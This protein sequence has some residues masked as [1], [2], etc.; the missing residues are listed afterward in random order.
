M[1]TDME[2]LFVGL[3]SISYTILELGKI[4][5]DSSVYRTHIAHRVVLLGVGS[6]LLKIVRAQRSLYGVYRHGTFICSDGKHLLYHFGVGK[7]NS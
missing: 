2:L 5:H 7:D 1:F 3:E 4:T 6:A